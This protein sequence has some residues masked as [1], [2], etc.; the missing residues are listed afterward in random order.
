MGRGSRMKIERGRKPREA[1]HVVCEGPV[2]L[3]V[4]EFED[5]SASSNMINLLLSRVLLRLVVIY[6]SEEGLTSY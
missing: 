4:D 1:S 2:T 5:S 6:E 3:V